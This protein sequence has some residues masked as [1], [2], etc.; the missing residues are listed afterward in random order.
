ME[1]FV[2][3]HT[4]VNNPENLC[5][6][7]IEMPLVKNYEKI[8]KKFFDNL[9]KNIE[10][11]FSSPSKR[12]TDLLECMN[13]EFSKR[14]ELK[15]LDFG[16]WEGRR[17]S[18]I[19]KADLNTWMNDFIYK[20]PKNGEK[21]IDLYNRVIDFTKNIFTMNL[22][23]VLFVT[24]AGVIRALLSK[25]LEISLEDTFNIK[26]NHDEIFS[27][28]VNYQKELELSFLQMLNINNMEIQKTFSK[29]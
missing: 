9:P 20:S 19:N 10:K 22:S 16:D 13:L 2:I 14:K 11:I 28:R 25:G 27:F 1:L 15:E 24:H 18:E 23:K 12:C 7:N 5:Y 6:G 3:R 21:M 17:W 29:Q 4:E 26:I 8:T